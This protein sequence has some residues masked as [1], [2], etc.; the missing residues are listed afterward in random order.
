[1]SLLFVCGLGALGALSR[2]GVSEVLIGAGAP[3]LRVVARGGTTFE[4]ALDG[5]WDDSAMLLGK[6]NSSEGGIGRMLVAPF[7]SEMDESSFIVGR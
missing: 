4:G 7:S 5:V 1:M 3:L 2:L 6:G